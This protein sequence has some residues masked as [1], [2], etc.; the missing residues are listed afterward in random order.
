MNHL[1]IKQLYFFITC[2]IRQFFIDILY[3]KKIIETDQLNFIV[4][5]V[6]NLCTNT[7]SAMSN[8][9]L[10]SDARKDMIYVTERTNDTILCI[11]KMK[12]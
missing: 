9:R 3:K 7:V 2:T 5:L 8:E 11:L 10:S 6:S 1:P 12:K 4:S